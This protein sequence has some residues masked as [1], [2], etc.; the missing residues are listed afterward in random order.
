MK[1][2]VS[3][4]DMC[5]VQGVVEPHYFQKKVTMSSGEDNAIQSL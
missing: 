1:R 2:F 5:I 3:L 4:H